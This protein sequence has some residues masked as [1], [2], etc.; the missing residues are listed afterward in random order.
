M[1]F[2]INR[3]ILF[4]KNVPTLAKFY[5]D[6]FGLESKG[7]PEKSWVELSAGGC[8]L[9]LHKGTPPPPSRGIPKFVFWCA[10]VGKARESLDK[11]GVALDKLRTFGDL[12]LCD[13]RDPEGN[14]F[15][16]SNRA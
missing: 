12:H 7:T 10:D 15:Q 5:Q 16:L 8:S 3:I 4:S 13:G 11:K 2:R 14:V 6:V 1:G 9:A